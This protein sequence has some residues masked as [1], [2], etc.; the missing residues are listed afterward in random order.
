MEL[1]K[2]KEYLNPSVEIYNKKTQEHLISLMLEKNLIN[3]VNNEDTKSN[4]KFLKQEILQYKNELFGS[5]EEIGVPVIKIIE[6]WE[7]I[8]EFQYSVLFKT[9]FLNKEN[10]LE[11]F[12]RVNLKFFNVNDSN[13]EDIQDIISKPTVYIADNEIILKFSLGKKCINPD[14][15]EELKQ[16]YIINMVFH[17]QSN[18]VEIRYNA[19]NGLF[20][21]DYKGFYKKNISA[22]KAWIN[23]FLEIKL[24]KFSLHYNSRE[25]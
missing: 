17:L 25:S 23:S 7:Y 19:I 9:E 16:K 11:K 12:R 22:V 20:I 3:E 14:T 8:R 13:L 5:I 15:E 21:D 4:K 2:Y 1:N 24:N 6:E 18:I 10:L